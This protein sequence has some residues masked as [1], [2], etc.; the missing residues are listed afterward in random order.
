MALLVV[1]GA[2]PSILVVPTAPTARTACESMVEGFSSQ[3][4]QVKL[5]GERS[6]AMACLAKRGAERVRC[7]GGAATRAKADGLVLVTVA[8]RG[9][10]ATVTL[11]LLSRQGASGRQESVRGPRARVAIFTRGAIV[12][13][14][15]AFRAMLARERVEDREPAPGPPSRSQAAID[16]PAPAPTAAPSPDAPVSARRTEA[17]PKLV[18]V[19]IVQ[20][21][22]RL[23]TPPPTAPP[24]ARRSPVPAWIAT[25]VAVAALGAAATFSGLALSDRARL[26]ATTGGVSSLSFSEATQL[27][28]RTNLELSIALGSGITVLLAGGT[29]GVLW[30]N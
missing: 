1:A 14:V 12:R 3:K 8:T 7:L 21:P 24:V 26:G 6:D 23:L 13:T 28:D 19:D 16:G 5:A 25:G 30:V 9:A 10:R 2:T 22:S 11:Q 4:V 17:L 20:P 27:R 15:G 18:E 29:A